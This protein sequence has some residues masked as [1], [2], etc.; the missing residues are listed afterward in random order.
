MFVSD[1]LIAEIKQN[2]QQPLPGNAAQLRMAPSH[3]DGLIQNFDEN[4]LIRKSAVLISLFPNN[5]IINTLLIKRAS[6][7]GIHS[8]QISFPGGKYEKSDESLIHT[9]LREAQ[10]EVGINP[11]KVEVLGTLTPLFIPVSNM[12]VLPV[13]GLLKEKPYLLLNPD[14]VEF[15]IEIPICHLKNTKNHMRKTISVREHSIEAPYI[16]VDSEDVWGATA[17]IISEFIELFSCQ[18]HR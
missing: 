12:E 17:M 9:A 14:E 15:I 18:N 7:D 11:F 1:K 5:E 2:L 13:I 4:R 16:N 10:E 3:R 6:Y 8:G